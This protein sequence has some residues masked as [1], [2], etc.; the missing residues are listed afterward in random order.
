MKSIYETPKV[1]I[2][3]LYEADVITASGGT[4]NGIGEDLGENDGEWM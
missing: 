3:L 1:E 2:F 4:N